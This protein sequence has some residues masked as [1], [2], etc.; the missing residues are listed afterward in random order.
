MAAILKMHDS[1]CKC[2][3]MS[4]ATRPQTEY[5]KQRYILWSTRLNIFTGCAKNAESRESRK[6]AKTLRRVSQ[7]HWRSCHFLGCATN[8]QHLFWNLCALELCEIQHLSNSLIE[9]LWSPALFGTCE[10][11][12]AVRPNPCWFLSFEEMLTKYETRC[13][14][15]IVENGL[16]SKTTALSRRLFVTSL[17]PSSTLLV[18][19]L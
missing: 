6:R 15:G 17:T 7:R 3:F 16:H 4:I 19:N 5:L 11:C 2:I 8:V 12:H 13:F 1:M 14:Q 18:A 10:H 9:I